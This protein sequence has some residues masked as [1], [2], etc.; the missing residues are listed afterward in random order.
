MEKQHSHP[1][2][3][4]P[5][6]IDPQLDTQLRDLNKSYI[7]NQNQNGNN[8]Q[9]KNK[10]VLVCARGQLAKKVFY[11]LDQMN[12]ET[13]SLVCN[14]DIGQSWYDFAKKTIF[15]GDSV[16]YINQDI[17]IWAILFSQCDYFFPGYTYLDVSTNPHFIKRMESQTQC[18]FMGAPSALLEIVN[19]KS[20][21]IP[22]MASLNIPTL[23]FGKSF[24]SY[25]SF[26]EVENHQYPMVF[27]LV[28][29]NSGFGN[30]KVNNVVELKKAI[31]QSA[32]YNSPFYVEK[33]ID[34]FLHIEV[35]FFNEHIIDLRNCSIQRKNQ[36]IISET[37]RP[38]TSKYK[39][40]L[41]KIIEDGHRIYAGLK[42]PTLGLFTIEFLIDT[43]QNASNCHDIYF[44]KVTP[45]IQ[46]EHSLTQQLYGAPFLKWHIQQFL[47]KSPIKLPSKYY[48]LEK[49][50]NHAIMV[51]IYAQDANLG[52]TP[53]TGRINKRILTIG[54][55][56]TNEFGFQEGDLIHDQFDSLIGTISVSNTSR[57][58]TIKSLK[59]AM[60]F[61]SIL[62]IKTNIF[63][64]YA[65]L[66]SKLFKSGEYNNTLQNEPH[67]NSKKYARIAC[68]ASVID[69][70][71]EEFKHCIDKVNKYTL[72]RENIWEEF[73][74]VLENSF[75]A[76]TEY[77]H[78]PMQ[79]KAN[80]I[81]WSNN[82]YIVKINDIYEDIVEYFP[83]TLDYF[84]LLYKNTF[85]SFRIDRKMNN[86]HVKMLTKNNKLHYIDVKVKMLDANDHS[87]DIYTI[88]APFQAKF[89]QFQD[90]N[91]V[92][93]LKIGDHVQKDKVLIILEAMNREYSITSPV[94]G[95]IVSIMENGNL[96]KLKGKSIHEDQIIIKIK[97]DKENHHYDEPRI[98]K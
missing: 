57:I 47:F 29:G 31:T 64:I 71:T 68:I 30:T 33:S 17:L 6:S 52:H 28:H 59:S 62:G 24:T 80:I 89:I 23:H 5:F 51:R 27:K 19:D 55:N 4:T 97:K 85:Y 86:Y 48:D 25:N 26:E 36:K 70:F 95:I 53:S 58:K 37:I 7:P 76:T 63:H 65:L 42:F 74:Q 83:H 66:S 41:E 96:H 90:S 10:A 93:S 8:N 78:T 72:H 44:L 21:L 12:V 92:N 9:K 1:N 84:R 40:E 82:K 16:N 46:I 79:I 50:K 69:R 38:Q 34:H 56:I 91:N 14:Q 43:T 18:H 54:Q 3:T 77:Q 11:I 39:K 22:L 73:P 45:R 15:I 75:V 20:I 98:T 94:S 81:L 13:V 60:K 87:D 61:M 49:I 2:V 32:R 67:E 88:K 35:Q